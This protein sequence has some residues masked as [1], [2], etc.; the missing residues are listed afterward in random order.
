MHC[1]IVW[2]FI[3]I[4]AIA[5]YFSDSAMFRLT[6]IHIGIE[7]D[8]IEI[9]LGRSGLKAKE[10]SGEGMKKQTSPPGLP[11]TD[12]KMDRR[13]MMRGYSETTQI[14]MREEGRK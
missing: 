13:S 7:M 14:G 10:K 12:R 3:H 5:L 4:I 11:N 6:G 9:S 2:P 8:S 1:W